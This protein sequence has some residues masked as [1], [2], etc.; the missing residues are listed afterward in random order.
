MPSS[1]ALR[2][3]ASKGR[4]G[5]WPWWVKGCVVWDIWKPYV[6]EDRDVSWLRTEPSDAA[7]VRGDARR[8]AAMA[9]GS[10][11]SGAGWVHAPQVQPCVLHAMCADWEQG[12]LAHRRWA[13]GCSHMEQSDVRG[14]AESAVW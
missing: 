12:G 13:P 5:M 7:Y 10:S 8:A 6:E 2:D 11:I 4:T 1:S 9:G 14:D 3:D